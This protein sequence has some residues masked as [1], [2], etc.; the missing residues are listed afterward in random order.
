MHLRAP[1]VRFLFLLL[2][3]I[4][5]GVIVFAFRAVI[6]PPKVTLHTVSDFITVP[7]GTILVEGNAVR[8]RS[9]R[10][11]GKQITQT[12]DGFF[13]VRVPTFAPYT[14]LEVVATDRFGKEQRTTY[15]LLVE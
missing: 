10:V 7:V 1:I 12:E 4:S 13:S 8:A 5:I 14:I 6:L 11:Q 9:I 15:T 3:L 2:A